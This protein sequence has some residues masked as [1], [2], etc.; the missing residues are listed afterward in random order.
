MALDENKAA[1]R[2]LLRRRRR[3]MDPASV[4]AA[5]EALTR[6]VLDRPDVTAAR[7]VTLYVSYGAEPGT[8]SLRAQ[9]L[10]RG[11]RI[12]LP[13]R[14]EDNDLDWAWDTGDAD[15]SYPL[16][17]PPAPRGPRLGVDA[18]TAADV[19]LVP[20]LAVD[21]DGVRLGQGAGCYDRALARVSASTPILVLVYDHEVLSRGGVPAEPHDRRATGW[22][23]PADAPIIRLS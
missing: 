21:G 1:L 23:T 4:Q 18:I 17:G 2:S 22:I 19:V 9:L 8:S 12:L 13:V 15:L 16:L 10:E 6:A 20:G 7:T 14:L 3:A 5:A 11:V